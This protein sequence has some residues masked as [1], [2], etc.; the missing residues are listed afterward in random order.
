MSTPMNYGSVPR[1]TQSAAVPNQRSLT[2]VCILIAFCIAAATASPAQTLTTLVDFNFADGGY[3][4]YAPLVLAPNGNYYGLHSR[5]EPS[6][7][8]P[9]SKSRQRAR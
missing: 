1:C 7:S 5:V 8:A 9:F 3:P 6:D 4:A 2:L